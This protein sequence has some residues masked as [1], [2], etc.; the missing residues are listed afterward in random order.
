MTIV[1][2]KSAKALAWFGIVNGAL[3]VVTPVLLSIFGT[4]S[5]PA[6]AF[7]LLIPLGIASI[8]A[9]LHGL[10]TKSWAFWLLFLTFFVQ[11]AE[12]FSESFFFSFIGPLSIKFGW[13][14]NSPPSHFNLNILAI[15]VCVFASRIAAQLASHSAEDNT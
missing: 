9:G 2:S 15:V 11:T 10:K 12:Y 13:G 4:Q 14:W 7:V 1:L 6:A 8:I 5:V 3:T